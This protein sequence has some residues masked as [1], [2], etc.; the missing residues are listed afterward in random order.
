MRFHKFHP[1]YGCL[2]PGRSSMEEGSDGGKLLNSWRLGSRAKP[3]FQ[4]MLLQTHLRSDATYRAP[5]LGLTVAQRS[6]V[7][8]PRGKL[9]EF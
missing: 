1:L 5:A 7:C 2:A 6:Y 8:N 9:L 3:A 4:A